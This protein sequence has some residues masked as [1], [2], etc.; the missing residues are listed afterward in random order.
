MPAAT[1]LTAEP[2][3]LAA[4]LD[5]AGITCFERGWLSSN[6]ILLRGGDGPNTLVDSGYATHADQTLALVQSALQDQPLDL[7][8][9]T[10][11]H[12]DHCGGNAALQ[13]LYAGLK[14]LIPPGQAAA[15][16]AWDP[17]ALT[18][19]PTGQTCERFTH[20]DL[21]QPGTS[22]Q[23]GPLHWDIHA[24]KGHDPHSIVLFQPEQRVLISADALWQN[25]FGIVF[26]ELEGIDAFDEVADTLDLIER[27]APLTVI[28]GHGAVFQDVGPALERARSRLQQFVQNP[29]KHR[30]HALKVLIKFK[31][32]EWQTVNATDL[33]QWM[34]RTSYFTLVMPSELHGQPTASRQWMDELLSEL[35]RSQALSRDG[36]RV[37][38]R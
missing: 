30:R 36:E 24:A 29:A 12:S 3:Q 17:V 18:F 14:T 2:A 33:H 6:N 31:L 22:M 27:L 28:P 38:N 19:E 7:L 11:L 37:I 10:H 13:A 5:G 26:P 1:P 4:A 16:A 25:G 21:L 34:L 23:L 32:L 15:V 20:R 35:E 9:N 8:L